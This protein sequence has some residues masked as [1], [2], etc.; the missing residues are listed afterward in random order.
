MILRHTP[1]V[2]SVYQ[3]NSY[4]PLFKFSLMLYCSNSFLFMSKTYLRQIQIFTRFQTHQKPEI[5][6]LSCSTSVIRIFFY[7]CH[8]SIISPTM[9]NKQQ[10]YSYENYPALLV[11]YPCK[12]YS[13]NANSYK[14]HN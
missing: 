9:C 3:T 1:F 13:Y 2:R 14:Y 11:Y 8:H 12:S 7:I 6:T 5:C 10:Q 4:I